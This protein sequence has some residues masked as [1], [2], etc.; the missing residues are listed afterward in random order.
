MSGSSILTAPLL[1]AIR[2]QHRLRWE[3]IHGVSH[4]AR[5][6]TIGL[7]LA[8]QTGAGPDVVELFAVFH[9]A[10][11]VNDGRDPDH[12]RRGA[13]LAVRLRGQVFDLPEAAL[14]FLVTACADHTHGH[15][16]APVT[17]Q[18]CWD[19]DRLDLGRVDIRPDPA[20]LCTPAAKDPRLFT[21]ATS[22]HLLGEA[23][24]LPHLRREA[25]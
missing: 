4:W 3:G 22:L 21:W 1:E 5:V 7:R 18:T 16:E 2:G 17:I 19:A 12:G 24:D 6:R 10:C 9:D 14:A 20:R 15:T 8:E 25:F 13:D 11:R 23:L